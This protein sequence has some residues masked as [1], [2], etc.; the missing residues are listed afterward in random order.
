MLR[1]RGPSG[2]LT[3]ALHHGPPYSI[4]LSVR[5]RTGGAPIQK[6]WRARVAER[7]GAHCLGESERVA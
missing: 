7:E 2:S 4:T 6:D 3:H 5:R 1:R